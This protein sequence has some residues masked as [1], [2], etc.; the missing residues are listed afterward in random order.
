MTTLQIP[1]YELR[2]GTTL[3]RVTIRQRIIIL[4]LLQDFLTTRS[5]SLDANTTNLWLDELLKKGLNLHSLR[6]YYNAVVHYLDIM[7]I[8][9][10]DPA[11]KAVKKRIPPMSLGAA[12]F[13]TV[14]EVQRL[15]KG[16]KDPMAKAVFLI[17]YSYGRRLGEVLA[18]THNNVD[19]K[20]GRIT[21][22]ILKTKNEWYKVQYMTTE[23][24]KV[25]KAW[26]ND[27]SQP[28]KTVERVL[29]DRVFPTTHR[30]IERI[31]QKTC[32]LVGVSNNGRKLRP[33]ILRHSRAT[34]ARAAGVPLDVV[35]KEI[36]CHARID[37]T[38]AFYRGITEP[39]KESVLSSIPT[40]GV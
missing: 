39:E 23:V 29:G 14:E 40:L 12:D 28:T 35:S 30:T 34:H 33:H 31:F 38:V 21:F 26:L 25:L 13:L 4:R 1:T 17:A 16:C 3:A 22:K 32:R 7:G 9:R 20:E 15:I 8:N 5:F 27:R 11:W 19:F 36:L 37:T 2:A 10:D 6:I 24:H 18:L